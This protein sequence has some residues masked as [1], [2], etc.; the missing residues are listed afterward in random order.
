MDYD[1]LGDDCDIKTKLVNF[2]QSIKKIDNI[3]EKATSADVYNNLDLKD[4]V[5]Y[6][7][8]MAYTLNTLYWLYLRSKNQD[9]SK[10]D[11]KNQLTRIKEYMVKRDQVPNMQFFTNKNMIYYFLISCVL[12]H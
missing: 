6:D 5:N 7:L 3:I 11:V 8:F 4:R 12:W 9:P 1:H 2:R 10:N